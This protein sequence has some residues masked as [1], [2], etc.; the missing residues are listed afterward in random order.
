[1]INEDEREMSIEAQCQLG[2]DERLAFE[3]RLNAEY[4]F[5]CGHLNEEDMNDDIPF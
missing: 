3:K 2:I 5:W 1:M 4:E